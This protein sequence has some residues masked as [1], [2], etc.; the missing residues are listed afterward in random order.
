MS[1][2]FAAAMVQN[3]LNPYTFEELYKFMRY[4]RYPNIIIYPL[5][6]YRSIDV[7]G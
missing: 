1:L 3:G 6:I 4:D 7:G 2:I 5:A